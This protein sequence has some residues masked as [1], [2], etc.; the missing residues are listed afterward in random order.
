MKHLFALIFLLLLASCRPQSQQYTIGVSQCSQDEWREK[1]N[2]EMQ[3]EAIVE[4]N[5]TLDFRSAKDNTDQQIKDIQ[6]FID[7]KVDL[8]IV[9]PNEVEKVTP[10][11]EKAFDAGIPVITTDRK[12][13]SDKYTAYAGADNRQIGHALGE[14]VRNLAKDHHTRVMAISGLP[15]SSPSI[16]R[17]QGMEEILND[18]P[19]VEMVGLIP[20]DW[21]METAE[22]AMDSVFRVRKDFD[23]VLCQNDRMAIGALNAA[24][25]VGMDK[26]LMFIGVDA[27]T[28]PDMGV[29]RIMRGELLASAIYPTGGENIVLLASSILKGQSF[30]RETTFSSAIVDSTNAR[31]MMLQDN[32][33]KEETQ[34]VIALT[35]QVDYYLE[36]YNL[37]QLLLT[38]VF[39]ILMLVI[40]LCAFIYHAYWTRTKNNGLLQSQNREI[41]E[42]RDQLVDLS[43]KLE[44]ATHAKLAFFTNVSHDFRTPLTL[45]ADPVNQL[46]ENKDLDENTQ[47]LANMIK[48]NVTILLRL[49]NQILDF[50]K[51][52]SGKLKLQLSEFDVV[53]RIEEWSSSF[54]ALAF[55]KHIR[56]NFNV[57]ESEVPYIMI[58]DS[59][60]IE[61]VLY[62]LLSNAFKFTPENGRISVDISQID[63]EGRTCLKLAVSDT[64]VGIPAEHVRHI[65]ENF[66]QVDVHHTGSG[67]G[68]ALSK[69]FV[70]MHQ[71]TIEVQSQKNEGARFEIIIPLRQ[72]GTLDEG[73][74]RNFAM[75]SLKEGAL[76]DAQQESLQTPVERGLKTEKKQI[77]VIDDN[78]DVRDYVRMLLQE[79]YDVIE[80]A[81]GK[82]GLHMALKEVPDLIICDVMMPIMDGMEC[83]RCLK[84]E[85]Q[86]SHIPVMMLTAYAMDDQKIEGYNC[87]ADSYISKPFSSQL[88]KTRIANL[89]ESHDRLQRYFNSDAKTPATEKEAQSISSLDK[90]FI[91]RLY[92]VIDKHLKDSELNV[93]DLGREL[94]F[95]R[96][97]LYRKTKALTGYS[98]NELV[99]AQRLKKATLLLTT[100]EKNISE[101]AYEV[102]FSSPS[103]FSKCYRDFYG[104]TPQDVLRR[105]G[106]N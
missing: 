42:Q 51:F 24:R 41:S 102:G 70:E 59:E 90:T 53:D 39:I 77:L 89:L 22:H 5:I 76:L 69:A 103:Y 98:P 79:Q 34:R 93:E 74:Q 11:I 55:K 101:I 26:Q 96:V 8:L 100:T 9:S 85:L 40:I 105:L 95:S 30:N 84:K 49:V 21:T 16:E 33:V 17:G 45:I 86:T 62:N 87:G 38:S 19:N 54:R 7:K 66:Y 94:G 63:R 50:R 65:F 91:E 35:S 83:C 29:E 80:A 6:Y 64:G 78:Q 25:K 99:R 32:L 73:L 52:E 2:E 27:L 48:K 1:Q 72:A 92:A 88:L 97:Q 68:L 31:I 44:E 82:E 4:R 3:R 36:Q 12:I 20:G 23:L 28:L 46:V 81:N 104:E 75:D 18:A 106:K 60:K 57:A 13:S 56:F 15:S 58:A 14:Y 37:Q 10:I 61:R 67:I 71:G 47:F 43:K